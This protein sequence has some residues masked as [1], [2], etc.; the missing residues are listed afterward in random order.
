MKRLDASRDFFFAIGASEQAFTN[1]LIRVITCPRSI[2]PGS[3]SLELREKEWLEL[4]FDVSKHPSQYFSYVWN[5]A[6][7]I[8]HA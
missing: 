2:T 5:A 4:G 6:F 3:E 1:R 7:T 8:D